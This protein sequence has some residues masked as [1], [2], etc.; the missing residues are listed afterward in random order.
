MKRIIRFSRFF[1]PA[2]VISA[3]L[4]IVGISGFVMNGGFNMGIDFQ[5]GL[6]Q[7]I[8]FAPTAFRLTHTGAGNVS[9][10]LS[11]TSL[12]FVITGTGVE[13]TA[14]RFVFTSYPTQGDLVQAIRE[15]GIDVEETAASTINS[16]WLIQSAQSSPVLEADR[17]FVLHYLP[18][19]ATPVRIEDLRT[20]LIPLGTVSVQILG[21]DTERRFMLRMEDREIEAA[22]GGVSSERILAALESTFGEGEVAVTRSDYV[23]SRFSRNL[24]D[25][26]GVLLTFTLLLVLAYMAIRFKL[27]YAIGAVIGIIYDGIIIVA[28]VVWTRME[29]NTT[30]IAA[31]LTILGYS[32][33]NTI[34]V[35]DRVRENLRIFPDEPFTDILNR[36]LSGTLGRTIITTLTTM[37]AVVPLFIFATG[38]MK[39]FALALLVGMT[40]GVYTT[41]FIASGFVNFWETKRAQKEKSRLALAPAGVKS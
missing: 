7:E 25:Q 27:R 19:N 34:V 4:V 30:T 8:Q 24:T 18:P 36:S 35:F 21:A 2:A 12:D 17:P 41:T 13:E 37:V 38:A 29:F 31:I 22:G 28:F 5:A 9:V 40:S 39:D 16:A 11:R 23:G 26:V 15:I 33:N 6:I 20:S 3:I 32:T 14:H 10:S 1:I